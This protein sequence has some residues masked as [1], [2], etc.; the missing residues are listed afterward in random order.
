VLLISHR[1][2]SVRDADRIYVMAEGTVVEEGTHDE[3]MSL[4]GLYHELFSIQASS[5]LD[6]PRA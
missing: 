6:A 2:S 3:L 5:Y 1:F 4:G